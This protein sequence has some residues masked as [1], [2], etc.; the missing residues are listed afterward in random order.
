MR[1]VAVLSILLA[2]AATGAADE[3][4]LPPLE[5]VRQL[6]EARIAEMNGDTQ[7]AYAALFR[8]AEQFP[9]ELPPVV[10]LLQHQMIYG[11][12]PEEVA[13]TIYFLCTPQASYVTGTEVHINGGQHV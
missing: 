9:T 7:A 10:E 2:F 12:T 8:A 4:H 6:R 3:Q 1:L 13:R 5:L 11:G